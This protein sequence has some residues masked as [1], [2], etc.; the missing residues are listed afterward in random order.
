MPKGGRRGAHDHRNENTI[1]TTCAEAVQLTGPTEWFRSNV[2]LAL[3]LVLAAT[4][5]FF[6]TV[7]DCARHNPGAIES[8]V[9]MMTMYL[10][11][12]HLPAKWRRK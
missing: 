2:S 4:F 8:V 3:G 9:I 7:I 12:G 11:F 1:E 6:K 10:H 5:Y